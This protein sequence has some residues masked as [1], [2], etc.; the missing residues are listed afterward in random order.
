MIMVRLWRVCKRRTLKA[1]ATLE[2]RRLDDLASTQAEADRVFAE[3][4]AKSE[5]ALSDATKRYEAAESALA[6]ATADLERRGP[7]SKRRRRTRMR[8]SRCATRRFRNYRIR[9]GTWTRL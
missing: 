5:A 2:Q 8:S 7:P 4:T 9:S 1:L 6:K 3:A